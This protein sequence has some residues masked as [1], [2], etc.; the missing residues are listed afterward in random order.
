[1]KLAPSIPTQQ[2]G[3]ALIMAILIVAL[4]TILAV[5]VASEGYM[6]Q[7]RTSTVMLMDQAFE[8]GLGAE[9]LAAEVLQQDSDAKVDALT[10][11]WA[12]PITLP[13]DDGVGDIKGNLEDLQGRFNINNLLN[14]NG[15]R[16]D[17]LV[18]QFQRLL[19]LLD[20][21]TKYATIT[22]DWI[23]ANNNEEFPGAEDTVYVAQNPAYLTP[24][25]PITRTSE[26]MSEVGMT[27]ETY[28]KL[29]PYIAALPV[30]TP[31]NV[32]TAPALLLDSLS[33]SLTQNSNDLDSF[34]T[35]RATGCFPRINDVK[36]SFDQDSDFKKL[37]QDHPEYLVETTIY[38][39]ANILVTL[40]T[41]EFALYSVLKRNGTGSN[42][43]AQIFQR[44][45][46]TH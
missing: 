20:I 2:R 46:G 41:T 15:T 30:G 34:N 17:T 23:D 39:R 43:K 1:M 29:E 4:A 8:M 32:C 3:V 37:M 10:E 27:Q 35:S 12:T 18:R 44:S 13:I 11:A 25:M 21:D 38:F 26:L 7:R 24:N 28:L 6:D 42:A 45:F 33:S 40:G 31:L 14:P 19:E 16:N 5:S 22:V 9:A 36:T